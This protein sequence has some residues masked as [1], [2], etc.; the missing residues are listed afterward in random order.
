[1]TKLNKLIKRAIRPEP[2]PMGFGAAARKPQAS[3][4]LVAIVGDH[5]SRAVSDAAAAGAD[6]L[7]LQ[8][9]PGDRDVS[10]AVEAAGER[11][12]GV[13]LSDTSLEAL[14]RLRESK[15]DFIVV[16]ASAPAAALNEGELAVVLHLR[17]D[18]TDMQ[19]RSLEAWSIDAIF[20]DRE[21]MPATI[22]RLLEVQRV[23]GLARK[24]LIVELPGETKQDDLLAL[25]E[26]GVALLAIDMKDRSAIDSLKR[27]RAT[28]D[29]L[30]R[31]KPRKDD[32]REAVLPSGGAGSAS[33]HGEEED[34]DE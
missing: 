4:L 1:M 12:C 8:G 33:E 3:M 17:E 25:R 23:S 28:V 7:M 2:E 27:L 16:G 9:K 31:Q 30:P 19:L 10:D 21:I 26:A 20:L 18:L 24:P 32:K 6:V 29:G 13:M 15:V 22:L 14:P 5:W 11:P 34:D